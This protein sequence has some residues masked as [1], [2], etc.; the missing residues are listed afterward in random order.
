VRLIRFVV[1]QSNH[2]WNQFIHKPLR[3]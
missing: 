2:E 1:S 3:H